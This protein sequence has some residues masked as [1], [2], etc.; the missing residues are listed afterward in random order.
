MANTG[1]RAHAGT[2]TAAPALGLTVMGCELLSGP[3]S[4]RS[5]VSVVEVLSR[6][7][8]PGHMKTAT[9]TVWLLRLAVHTRSVPWITLSTFHPAALGR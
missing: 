8:S 2:A 1:H 6:I 4:A 7:R 5:A 3:S 9:A